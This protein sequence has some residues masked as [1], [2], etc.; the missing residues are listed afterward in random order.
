V[1]YA[2][3]H[4]KTQNNQCQPCPVKA[5][6]YSVVCTINQI[7]YNILT[8]IESITTKVTISELQN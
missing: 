7:I 6:F 5:D 3:E 2:Y 4:N 1:N 8:T